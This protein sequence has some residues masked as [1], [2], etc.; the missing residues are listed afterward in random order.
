MQF[1]EKTANLN[2]VC[3]ALLF[4]Y[5]QQVTFNIIKIASLNQNKQ[6]CWC[7]PTFNEK[8]GKL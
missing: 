6:K 3:F 1:N 7:C 8:S 5:S 2:T 4:S